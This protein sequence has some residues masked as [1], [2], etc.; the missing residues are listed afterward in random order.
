MAWDGFM[1]SHLSDNGR[2][3]Y[4]VLGKGLFYMAPDLVAFGGFNPWV[5][6]EDPEAGMRLWKQGGRLGVIAD[7]L[8]EEVPVTFGRGVT[9]RKRWVCGFFQSLSEPLRAMGFTPWQRFRARLNLV[10]CLSLLIN[11]VG[12]PLG[13]WAI[14]TF[15]LGVNPLPAALIFLCL[16]TLIVQAVMLSFIYVSTWRRTAIVLSQRRDRLRYMLRVSPPVLYLYWIWWCVPIVIGFGMYLREG[17][18]TWE[19]TTKTDANHELVREIR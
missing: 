11:A 14:V 19:R 15:I 12:I 2:Q 7:P 9:Q 13:I 17:G 10:P 18:L 3:P 6:I 8:I 16:T 4:W 5:A 1:Y